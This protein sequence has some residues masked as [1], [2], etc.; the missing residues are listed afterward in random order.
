MQTSILILLMDILP[1]LMVL[2][3]VL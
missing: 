3:S 2:R 1:G